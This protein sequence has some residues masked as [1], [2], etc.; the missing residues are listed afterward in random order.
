MP[1]FKKNSK[2]KLNAQDRYKHILYAFGHKK[3]YLSKALTL[4]KSFLLFRQ[5]INTNTHLPS[6]TT[7]TGISFLATPPASNAI[8]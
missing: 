6:K 2:F 5:L 8:A 7:G 1:F 3:I 4:P